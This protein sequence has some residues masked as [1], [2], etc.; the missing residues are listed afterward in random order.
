[1]H[2][3]LARLVEAALALARRCKR[4]RH[5]AVGTLAIVPAGKSG[6]GRVPECAARPMGERESPLVLDPLQ[7]SIRGKRISERG[8]GGGVR[9]RR[10]DTRATDGDASGRQRALRARGKD[11]RQRALAIAA[12]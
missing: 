10:G 11:A 2:G 8:D 3:D 9:R 5:N 1:M 4:Q 6:D 7:Q 12:Q